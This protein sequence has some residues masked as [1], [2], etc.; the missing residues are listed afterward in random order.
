[1]PTAMLAGPKS[2][3]ERLWR[4]WASQTIQIPKTIYAAFDQVFAGLVTQAHS[5]ASHQS[6]FGGVH[7][8]QGQPSGSGGA[9]KG[10]MAPN[11][12]RDAQAPSICPSKP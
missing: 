1:M 12:I 2:A 3:R 4:R 7:P 6:I 5:S 9:V 10:G 11:H 8:L